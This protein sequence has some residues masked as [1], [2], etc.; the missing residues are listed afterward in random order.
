MY[1]IQILVRENQKISMLKIY[2][3][4]SVYMRTVMGG[5]KLPIC[6]QGSL[7]MGVRKSVCKT[8]L[9]TWVQICKIGVMVVLITKALKSKDLRQR[10]NTENKVAGILY[11]NFLLLVCNFVLLIRF[12]LI[13]TTRG[14]LKQNLILIILY[15]N[16]ILWIWVYE[17]WITLICF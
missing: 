6:F 15:N 3:Y 13:L 4:S 11:Q 16:K 12:I 10:L 8:W 9:K 5:S 1:L 14:I 17:E 7:W 2:I